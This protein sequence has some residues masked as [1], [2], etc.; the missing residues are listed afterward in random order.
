MRYAVAT[1]A[2]LFLIGSAPALAAPQ[3]LES[4]CFKK[5]RDARPALRYDEREA[6]I[7]NCIADHTPAP[8]AKRRYYK[9]RGY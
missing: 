8:G 5:A 6:Y 7:A 9:Q 1:V 4:Y 3:W 2:C